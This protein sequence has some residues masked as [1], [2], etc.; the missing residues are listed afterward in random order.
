MA[1]MFVVLRGKALGRGSSLS[2][3]ACNISWRAMMVSVSRFVPVCKLDAV[4]KT[5]LVLSLGNR[6]MPRV[7]DY[8]PSGV[9]PE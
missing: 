3:A 2:R 7:G 9:N 6:L 1:R 4:L 8:S 5:S